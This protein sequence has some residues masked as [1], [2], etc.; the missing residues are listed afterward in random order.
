MKFLH[1]RY[2]IVRQME[3][4]DNLGIQWIP[5][6]MYFHKGNF[7]SEYVNTDKKGFRKNV[8][9]SGNYIELEKIQGSPINLLVGNS[10][11]FGVGATKD[12]KTLSSCLSKI[13]NKIWLNWGGRA[14]TST[15]EFIMFSLFHQ[16]FKSINHVI[17]FTGIND[18]VYFSSA[19]KYSEEMGSVFFW[20]GF[21]SGM[22][23]GFYQKHKNPLKQLLRIFVTILLKIFYNYSHTREIN[24]RALIGILLRQ[25]SPP[26]SPPA[27]PNDYPFKKVCNHEKEKEKVINTM[28]RNLKNWK[29]F[30]KELGFKLIFILQPYATWINKEL[31][32][33]EKELFNIL[34]NVESNNKTLAKKVDDKHLWI[35]SR[36]SEICGKEG[37]EFHDMNHLLKQEKIDNKWIFV[38]RIHMTDLGYRYCANIINELII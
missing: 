23:K 29:I 13:T 20:E 9:S 28:E 27:E 37:I 3:I 33:E 16:K 24:T 17:L 8:D 1:D 21:K 38:D 30:S 2:P 18:L 11:A 31:S 5:F 15:Q 10:T 26:P 6:M 36:L 4:Y 22:D 19:N 14:F 35:S 34:D 7:Q 32:T 25:I 12:S